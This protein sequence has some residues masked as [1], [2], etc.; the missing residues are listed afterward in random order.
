LFF[1]C[2]HLLGLC[3]GMHVAHKWGFPKMYDSWHGW[4]CVFM[5]RGGKVG[6]SSPPQGWAGIVEVG[7]VEM[8]AHARVEQSWLRFLCKKISNS[9]GF[10]LGM[11]A[12]K[13]LHIIGSG[14]CFCRLVDIM[15]RLKHRFSCLS[16]TSLNYI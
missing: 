15:R 14:I 10:H 4:W 2:L 1:F 9:C 3:L 5:R 11:R 13:V 7:Q 8:E 12:C 6:G 16:P